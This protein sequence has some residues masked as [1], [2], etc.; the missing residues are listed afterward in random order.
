MKILTTII[1]I[2]IFVLIIVAPILIYI[3]LNRKKYK[4]DKTGSCLQDSSGKYTTLEECQTNCVGE[5]KRYEC[6]NGKCIEDSSGKYT[7]L[8]ECQNNCEQTITFY[9]EDDTTETFPFFIKYTYVTQRGVKRG[10]YD[11]LINKTSESNIFKM[12]N[13]NPPIKFEITKIP[14]GQ[15]LFMVGYDWNIDPFAPVKHSCDEFEI[16]LHP[17]QDLKKLGPSDGISN[18]LWANSFNYFRPQIVV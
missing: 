11:E 10:C 18:K 6:K 14:N 12:K 15:F 4:C 5:N 1:Y 16:Q 2:F 7:T 9:F 8:E 17:G 3:L 13:E